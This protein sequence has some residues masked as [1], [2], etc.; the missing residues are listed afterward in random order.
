MTD[1]N[2]DSPGFV[3]WWGRGQGSLPVLPSLLPPRPP[4][5]GGRLVE[6]RHDLRRRRLPRGLWRRRVVAR[7]GPHRHSSSRGRWAPPHSLPRSPSLLCRAV[8]RQRGWLIQT[9][10]IL[11]C[12]PRHHG[13]W[14]GRPLPLRP[15]RLDESATR[16]GSSSPGRAGRRALPQLAPVLLPRL[17]LGVAPR[18][19]LLHSREPR[20]GVRRWSGSVYPGPL[21]KIR[22]PSPTSSATAPCPLSSRFG[23]AERSIMRIRSLTCRASR[24]CGG[25]WEG[26]KGAWY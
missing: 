26:G 17:G 25:R 3:D 21:S 7:H 8:L 18:E 6:L 11:R 10:A 15:T 20:A 24:R 19:L 12:R 14:R 9:P 23:W 2:Y 4:Q 13:V 1:Y 22:S 16:R 5:V